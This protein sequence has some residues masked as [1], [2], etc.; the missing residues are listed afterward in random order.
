MDRINEDQGGKNFIY[1]PEIRISEGLRFPFLPLLH[2]FLHF[3][4]T[5]PCPHPCEY[6]LCSIGRVRT[7][8]EV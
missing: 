5:P 6:H 8:L 2:Q 1:W 4:P 3:T 7:Q